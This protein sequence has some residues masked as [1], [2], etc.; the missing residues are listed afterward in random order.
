MRAQTMIKTE[1]KWLPSILLITNQ[2]DPEQEIAQVKSWLTTHHPEKTNFQFS[3]Y[4][5][6]R[7][8]IPIE[9][10]RS[11]T[12]ELSYTTNPSVTRVMVLLAADMLSEPAQH[13]LLKSLEE[14]TERT[15]CLLIA[16]A[17]SSL[18][19]TIK[20]RCHIYDI[21]KHDNF[22]QNEEYAKLISEIENQGI[23]AAITIAE[24]FKTK[25]DALRCLHGVLQSL[26]V[27]QIHNSSKQPQKLKKY[28]HFAQKGFTIAQYLESNS[29]PQM[30]MESW[31]FL[32]T[33][34]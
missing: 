7:E 19:P 28:V 16:Q 26:Y 10:V 3:W 34:S 17:E 11:F 13:A 2:I 27:N 30:T 8:A 18:L 23:S 14:P 1:P 4:N 21:R 25:A 9:T 32:L 31:F 29:N 24:K 12:Q 5:Q 15:Q 33:D 22:K 6:E 20:S